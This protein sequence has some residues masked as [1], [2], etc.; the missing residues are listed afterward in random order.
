MYAR[1]EFTIHR[2]HVLVLESGG[3]NVTARIGGK[4]TWV[5][6]TIG[7]PEEE[8]VIRVE[9]RGTPSLPSLEFTPDDGRLLAS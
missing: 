5:H 4:K 9:M 1:D 2:R 8:N 3:L 6:F 7:S